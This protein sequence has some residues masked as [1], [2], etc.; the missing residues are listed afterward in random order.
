MAYSSVMRAIAGVDGPLGVIDLAALDRNIAALR[1]RAGGLPIR[2]ATKSVRV[3]A[4][5]DRVLAAD[6]Y[7]GLLAFSL[8]EALDLHRRGFRDILVA[9][10]TVHR[11][12]LRALATD[13]DAL[14]HITLV[15]DSTTGV[16]LV[17][18]ALRDHAPGSRPPVRLCIEVDASFRPAPRLTRGRVHLGARRSPVRGSAEALALVEQIASRPGCRLV[19][20]LSYEGQIAGLGDAGA[21][22]RAHVVRSVRRPSIAELAERR[23]RVIADIR[24]AADLEFVNGGGTGSLESSVAEGTLT[25][26]AAGSGPLSPHLF[27][28]YRGFRHEPAAFFATPVVRVPAPGWVTVYGGGWV[29]SGPPGTAR[30]PVPVWPP[31]LRYAPTEGPGE[32]QTPLHGPGTAEL[33]IGDHVL[34]RHAKAG[35][36]AEHL[37]EYHVVDDGTVVATWPTY[38]GSG[39]TH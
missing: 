34:F 37:T 38:R 20:V 22:P 30:L 8:P 18:A 27:D 28:G 19:G 5:L 1:R 10:P 4:V 2:V 6:G 24:A 17:L 35:E 21:D 13:A 36:L 26:V 11:G 14:S 12:A 16:D 33:A 32:V 23:T 31:G 39:W 29:A 25:E 7:R 3:P 15:V 9:Y